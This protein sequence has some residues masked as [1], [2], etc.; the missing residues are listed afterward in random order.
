MK[1]LGLKDVVCGVQGSSLRDF[2]LGLLRSEGLPLRIWI[3]CVP[4][5]KLKPDL[6]I[7]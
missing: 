2:G 5:L 3:S 6:D 7:F 1:L 4:K